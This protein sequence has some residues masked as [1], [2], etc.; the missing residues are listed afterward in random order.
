MLKIILTIMD[1]VV[2]IGV[3][4]IFGI[5]LLYGTDAPEWAT[6]SLITII[7]LQC[8]IYVSAGTDKEGP[9]NDG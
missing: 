7:S 5:G 1:Y 4:C 2:S 8:F 3:G 9:T 6:I